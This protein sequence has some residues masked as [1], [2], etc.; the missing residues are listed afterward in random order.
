[1]KHLA[2][3]GIIL[4]GKENKEAGTVCFKLKIKAHINDRVV[5]GHLYIT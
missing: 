4:N 1:M 3:E 5:R 2:K